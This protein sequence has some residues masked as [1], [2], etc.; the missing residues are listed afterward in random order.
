[1][2][3]LLLLLLLTIPLLD[4]VLLLIALFLVHPLLGVL[5]ALLR[6]PEGAVL[7]V[8]QDL[9]GLDKR[10][11]KEL[12]EDLE[13]PLEDLFVLDLDLEL[14]EDMHVLL[15]LLPL[16]LVHLLHITGLAFVSWLIDVAIED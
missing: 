9:R 12:L 16:L 1:M 3:L 5:V 4:L 10:L 11:L 6:V 7:L 8:G 14:R 2:A 15:E 13:N